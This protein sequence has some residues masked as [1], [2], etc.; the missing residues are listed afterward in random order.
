MERVQPR[1]APLAAALLTLAVLFAWLWP[2]GD[3][4]PPGDT[5]APEREATADTVTAPLE[6]GETTPERTDLTDAQPAP[7]PEADLEHPFTFDLQLR[8][9]DEYGLPVQDALVFAAPPLCGYSL[10]PQPT[11]AHGRAHLQWQGRQH[12]MQMHLTT[13]S[14][15]ELQPTHL[16]NLQ[17]GQPMPLT[18]VIRGREPEEAALDRVRE[19]S[20]EQLRE[21]T[22]A[23]RYGRMQKRDGLDVLCGRTQFLFREFLCSN[24]HDKSSIADYS[25][26]AR[27]GD[28]RPALHPAASFWDLRANNVTD[29]QVQQRTQLLERSARAAADREQRR[30][31]ETAMVIG[32][33][34]DAR[35]KAVPEVPVVWQTADGAVRR[36][37]MT[38]TRGRYRLENCAPGPIE[39]RAGGGE[40][41]EAR[42]TIVAIAGEAVPWNAE[43]TATSIVRGTARDETG[44]VL[45][46]WRVEYERAER[47]WADVTTVRDDGTFLFPGAPGLGQCLLWP[48]GNGYGLPVLFGA[49]ALP[50]AAPV[51]L[52]LAADNPT[53]ARLRLRPVLPVGC[54]WAQVETRVTQLQ[55]G[56]TA[57]LRPSGRDEAFEL[58][59]LAPGPYRVEVGAP[60][61]G[62]VD[63]RTIDIDG[64]GLWDLGPVPLPMPGRLRVHT[65]AGVKSPLQLEHAFCRRLPELD[66]QETYRRD[67]DDDLLLAAGEHVLVWRTKEGRRSVAFSLIS[68]GLTELTIAAR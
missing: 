45:A 33:V 63:C 47:D 46:G 41:G 27:C 26:L 54:S 68:G 31:T 57:A 25:T 19:R 32:A 40:A 49:T 39:L 37:T 24:C 34:R 2:R 8:L 61:L 42:A 1:I 29:Q 18:L 59:G 22:L 44:G 36:R 64:R 60:I 65:P 9:I 14:W 4:V 15:G 5:D 7:P 13:M 53:R 62:W 6:R 21:D 23:V 67:G 51:T 11:D 66:V 50:D 28:M 10:W 16:L 55:T 3:A 35:G 43:L 56:R 48:K 52:S 20:A 12:H 38:N 17:A 58:E 30:R